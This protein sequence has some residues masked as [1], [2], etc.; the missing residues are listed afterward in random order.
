LLVEDNTKLNATLASRLDE[1]EKLKKNYKEE[2][3]LR[4]NATVDLQ[5]KH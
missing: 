5:I 3:L 1:L 2:I 4:D